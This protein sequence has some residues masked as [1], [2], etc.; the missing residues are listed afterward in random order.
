MEFRTS[1]VYYP[2][3]SLPPTSGLSHRAGHTKWSYFY[4][5]LIITT[6]ANVFEYLANYV[7]HFWRRAGQGSILGRKPSSLLSLPPNPAII[8]PAPTINTLPASQLSSPTYPILANFK[9]TVGLYFQ[10]QPK[11]IREGHQLISKAGAQITSQF[12]S[13][14]VLSKS[15]LH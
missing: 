8:A 2:Q 15:P 12:L 11:Q 4:S 3:R 1:H 5:N 9:L 14:P 10:R 7:L 13:N 6:A